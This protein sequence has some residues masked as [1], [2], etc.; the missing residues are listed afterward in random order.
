MV[1]NGADQSTQKIGIGPAPFVP[2]VVDL[3]HHHVIRGD[4][5][6]RT[7]EGRQRRGPVEL[8]APRT[9]EG[10]QI[11]EPGESIADGILRTIGDPENLRPV[12]GR[13]H[14][15]ESA[16][17][18]RPG[19]SGPT[20]PWSRAGQPAPRQPR[21]GSAFPGRDL[22]ER[23]PAS[24]STARRMRV[25]LRKR[26]PAGRDRQTGS[27]WA[28]CEAPARPERVRRPPPN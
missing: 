1:D 4:D 8:L 15:H 27:V 14:V 9:H 18:C 23:P 21:P 3:D 6:R 11:V 12:V 13:R 19:T 2:L 28:R 7:R 16:T 25:K 5:A 20:S 10:Q 26:P 24:R 22:V 17:S